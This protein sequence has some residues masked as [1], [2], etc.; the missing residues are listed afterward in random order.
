MADSSQKPAD[1]RRKPPWLKVKAFGGK[2]FNDINSLLKDQGLLTVCQE[3]NCPNRG[4]CFSRGTATFLILGPLCTRNCRFCNVTPGKPSAP[5]QEEP[6]LVAEAVARMNLRHAVVTSVTRDDLP[7]G[8]AEQFAQTIREIRRLR[9]GC[10]IEILTPDFRGDTNALKTALQAKPTIFNHNVETVPD[11]YPLVRP[12]AIYQRS[13]D[14]L[15]FAHEQFGVPVK[16]GLMVGL[17]ETTGQLQD[18]FA[19]LARH[20]VSLLTI[21]QYLQPTPHHLPVIR[22]LPPEEFDLLATLARRAGIRQVFAGPLV[23]SSYLADT[24]VSAI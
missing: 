7:D 17:G 20:H 21:G 4:E 22:Y 2:A 6:R 8:G 12:S 1:S 23:R 16:S 19:N 3:A 10:T 14:V 5:N 11:L 18:T 24:M 13:L 15:Q 9:P